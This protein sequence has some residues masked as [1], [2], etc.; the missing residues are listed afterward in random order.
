MAIKAAP[1]QNMRAMIELGAPQNLL[2]FLHA[3]DCG[4]GDDMAPLAAPR[5]IVGE[6]IDLLGL[7]R[8]NPGIEFHRRHEKLGVFCRKRLTAYFVLCNF[9]Q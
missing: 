6:G 4:I 9:E 8:R 5:E 2:I 1:L 3:L 7:F